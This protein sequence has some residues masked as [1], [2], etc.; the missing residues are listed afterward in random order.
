MTM[1]QQWIVVNAVATVFFTEVLPDSI[2]SSP[3]SMTVL[4]VFAAFEKKKEK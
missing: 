1:V 3:S 4:C 2:M